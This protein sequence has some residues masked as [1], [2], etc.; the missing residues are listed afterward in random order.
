MFGGK[1]I[2]PLTPKFPPLLEKSTF[3]GG[4]QEHDWSETQAGGI[5][6]AN[7]QSQQNGGRLCPVLWKA[8]GKVTGNTQNN[9]CK[10]RTRPIVRVRASSLLILLNIIV[11]LNIPLSS[12][13]VSIR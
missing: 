1:V 6:M 5:T 12:Y 9:A 2:T 11:I 10:I 13:P 7:G 3:Y 8:S 4:L